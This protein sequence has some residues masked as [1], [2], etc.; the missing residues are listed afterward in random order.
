MLIRVFKLKTA[1]DFLNQGLIRE[2]LSGIY[3]NA[4][5]AYLNLFFLFFNILRIYLTI[6]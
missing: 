1:A 5:I 2:T 3:L 4:F 6:Y